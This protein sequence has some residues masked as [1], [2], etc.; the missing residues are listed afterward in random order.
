M[1]SCIVLSVQYSIARRGADG[2]VSRQHET[3]KR[4]A[5]QSEIY[6]HGRWRLKRSSQPIDKQYEEWPVA[7]RIN[8]TLLC[9]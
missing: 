5:Y 8:L 9:M 4:P 3:H 2:H 7:A 6:A 1:Y